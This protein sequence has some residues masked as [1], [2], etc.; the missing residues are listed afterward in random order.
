MSTDVI[1]VSP[2]TTLKDAAAEMLDTGVS[3]LPVTDQGRL[4]GIITEADFV[5]RQAAADPPP[6]R[7]RPLSVIF[8]RRRGRLDTATTVGQVMS[9]DLV[10]VAPEMRVSRAAR[11]M[12]E[13]GVKRLPVVDGAGILVGVI[14]RADVMRVFARS[15]AEIAH[16]IDELMNRRLLPV[17]PGDVGV[18]VA[19]GVVGLRGRVDARV[20]AEVLVDIVSRMDGV[21]SVTDDLQWDVDSRVPP[22]RYAGFAQEGKEGH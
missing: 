10:T 14:S 7:Y 8:G 9:T 20:D 3:G 15:D 12:V 22:E 21:L 16:E 11:F 6:A 18:E 2:Q 19:D 17:S 1:T 5:E 4:V 13:G